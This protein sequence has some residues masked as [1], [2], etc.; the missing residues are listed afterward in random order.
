[1]NAFWKDPS[2][3]TRKVTITNETAKMYHIEYFDNE[4]RGTMFKAG[5][6]I[7]HATRVRLIVYKT[8]VW[9]Q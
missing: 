3:R 9:F 5:R 7:S 6:K 1:M 2:G 4:R 8:E